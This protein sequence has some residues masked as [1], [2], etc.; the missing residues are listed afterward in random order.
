LIAGQAAEHYGIARY[1][2]L[3]AWATQLGRNDYAS[4]LQK[5][6]DGEKATDGKLTSQAESK[7][8]RRAAS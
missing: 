4:V 8:N 6:L 3:I 2:S 1:G 5:T 7:V